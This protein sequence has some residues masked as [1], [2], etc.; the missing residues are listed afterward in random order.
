MPSEKVQTMK[1]RSYRLIWLSE[2]EPVVEQAPD[3]AKVLRS[4]AARAVEHNRDRAAFK[5]Q[6]PP[7]H[8][9]RLAEAL[10]EVRSY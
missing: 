8:R 5:F 4:A 6:P 10:A 3:L 7:R 1:P 2:V 9:Q